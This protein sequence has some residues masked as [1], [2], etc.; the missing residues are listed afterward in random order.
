MKENF[1]PENI[2]LLAVWIKFENISIPYDQ[3]QSDQCELFM[4]T[5]INKGLTSWSKIC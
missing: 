4:L 3:Y 1:V 5:F 2:K